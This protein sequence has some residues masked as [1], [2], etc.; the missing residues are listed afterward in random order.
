MEECMPIIDKIRGR[1]EAWADR[2]RNISMLLWPV[3]APVL[4][5]RKMIRHSI[6]R[7]AERRY[8]KAWGID[9]GGEIT[10]KRLMM[11]PETGAYAKGY[12]GTPPSIAEHLIGLVADRARGFT[13][14]DYGAGKGRV[15]LIAARYQFDRVIGV[16]LSEPLIRIAT[17]NVGLYARKHPGLR[18]IELVQT[19]AAKYEL[20]HTPCVLFL[21]DPFQ[22]SLM[23]QIGSRVRASFLA[24][25]R[26]LFI[27]YYFP[28]FAHVFEAPFMRRHDIT[29]LPSQSMNRYG[30]PTASIFETLP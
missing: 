16:E 25:P 3:L 21:Y 7:A 5:T 13:F 17:A 29:D 11:T 10:G 2:N 19:D 9:T 20:P 12:A 6:A 18:P 23:E 1:L 24:S 30:K 27:I 28:A 14:V 4:L 15:L 22:A 26:K 8:D